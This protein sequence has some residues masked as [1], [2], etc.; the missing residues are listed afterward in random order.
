MFLNFSNHPVKTWGRN[1]LYEAKK[2]GEVRDMSFP[3]VSAAMSADDI[4]VLAEKYV[5]HIVAMQ[6]SCVL[7]QGEFTL[8]Y[9]VVSRLITRGIRVVAACSERN[10]RVI[11][12]GNE[13]V[14]KVVFEFKRFR[15]YR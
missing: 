10:V 2:F 5:N 12:E 11:N 6:P 13:T 7:C 4:S 3:D 15:E 1:Q 9:A 14:K 8:A